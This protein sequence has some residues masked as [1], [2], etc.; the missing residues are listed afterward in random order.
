MDSNQRSQ[1]Y[2][3]SMPSYRCGY[4]QMDSVPKFRYILQTNYVDIHSRLIQFSVSVYIY[5]PCLAALSLS[6][7]YLYFYP[8]AAHHKIM[9]TMEIGHVL[10]L[11]AVL[12]KYSPYPT[13]TGSTFCHVGHFH[14]R[15]YRTFYFPCQEQRLTFSPL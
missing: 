11:K 9:R 7:A 2:L 12:M 1:G 8:L 4:H 15:K 3:D 13:Y 5:Q 10:R 6:G 14:N